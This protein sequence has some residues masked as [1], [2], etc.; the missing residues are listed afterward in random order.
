MGLFGKMIGNFAKERVTNTKTAF[1]LIVEDFKRYILI[2]KWVF[3]A[4]S[5]ATVIFDIVMNIGN[6]VIN[7]CLLG[8]LLV[9]SVLDTLFRIF[10]KPDPT[11]KLRIVYAWLRIT[12]N[13][14]A[15][16]SS[17][18]AIYSAAAHEV[19]PIT[20]VLAT[21]SLIM[22]ILKVLVE[23]CYEIFQ[24]KWTL[25]KNA[26]IMDAKEHPNTSGKLF[27]PL[28]GDVEEVEVKESVAERIKRKQN[29]E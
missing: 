9:Y 29:E 3:L 26:M 1:Q 7:C 5:F 8:L 23:I 25:L 18:Y 15:V 13:A 4:F 11:K 21:L 14:A 6:L 22:F 10:R 12:L 17:L 19:K 16:I 20:I 24:S 28:I 27:S 2:L